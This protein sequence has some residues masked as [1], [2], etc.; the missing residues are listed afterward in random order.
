MRYP[1]RESAIAHGGPWPNPSTDAT[2][3]F[4]IRRN[5]ETITGRATPSGWEWADDPTSD[6]M[7][8]ATY[9]SRPGDRKHRVL[10]A[11]KAAAQKALA[12]ADQDCYF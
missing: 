9:G 5:G 4:T 1:N 6:A 11:M 3:T 12:R 7:R 8:R 10:M 2:V